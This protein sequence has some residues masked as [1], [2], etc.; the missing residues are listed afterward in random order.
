MVLLR[1][2]WRDSRLSA[3]V[4]CNLRIHLIIDAAAV[5]AGAER[6]DEP[7]K[8][9]ATEQ[10]LSAAGHICCSHMTMVPGA[11]DEAACVVQSWD[12]ES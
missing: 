6:F 12:F 8:A 5:E 9:A 10:F 11:Q 4:R 3:Q 1:P 7:P 2:S